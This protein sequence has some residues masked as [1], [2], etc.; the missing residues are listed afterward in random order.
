MSVNR[1]RRFDASVIRA[2]HRVKP[3]AMITEDGTIVEVMR[4][5]DDKDGAELVRLRI[6]E[7]I[8]ERCY[9]DIMV[10]AEFRAF[11]TTNSLR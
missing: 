10:A 11:Y 7:R 4:L 3:P 2:G 1:T 6:R 9:R 8:D 5:V